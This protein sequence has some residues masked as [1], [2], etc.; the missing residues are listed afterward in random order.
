M[1]FPFQVEKLISDV[2]KKHGYVGCA[3][4][5]ARYH[6]D[7]LEGK[8]EASKIKQA[9]TVNPISHTESSLPKAPQTIGATNIREKNKKEISIMEGDQLQQI[10][11]ASLIEQV[12]LRLNQKIYGYGVYVDI[13]VSENLF[14]WAK[15]RCY[16]SS[17]L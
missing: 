17:H 12:F 9:K 14:I 6:E 8:P 5:F 10:R 16:L 3:K 2:L 11:L 4:I 7:L 15:T 1:T 13:E